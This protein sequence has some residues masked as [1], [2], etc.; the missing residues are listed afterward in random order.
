MMHVIRSFAAA[1]LALGL[2]PLSGGG[3]FAQQGQGCLNAPCGQICSHTDTPP[4]SACEQDAEE[5][6]FRRIKWALQIQES[7]GADCAKNHG[8]P[9]KTANPFL[10]ASYGWTQI[11]VVTLLTDWGK[12]FYQAMQDTGLKSKQIFA[13]KERIEA[14][15]KWY[16]SVK[17]TSDPTTVPEA[18]LKE[19]GLSA[20]DYRRL[21]IWKKI[22]QLVK[23]KQHPY[24][25]E[26]VEKFYQRLSPEESANLDEWLK[27]LGLKRGNQ[28]Y[29]GFDVYLKQK[30][31]EEARKGFLAKAALQSDAAL[32]KAVLEQFYTDK[33]RYD[34]VSDAM[35]NQYL[36]DTKEKYPRGDRETDAQYEARL[37]Q[38]VAFYHNRGHLF[39]SQPGDTLDYWYTREFLGHWKKAQAMSAQ[40]LCQNEDLADRSKPRNTLKAAWRLPAY[41]ESAPPSGGGKHGD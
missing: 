8:C 17:P 26:S 41:E 15:D 25:K 34:Q 23:D 7:Q 40:A 9:A 10:P 32:R 37:A 19:T 21:V 38:M 12:Q 16:R 20:E 27:T 13:A 22:E 2:S 24:G 14:A 29:T 31:W 4:P 30:I 28:Y 1:L 18:F 39:G 33:M 3:A 36:E 5:L 6:R 35:I 11:T